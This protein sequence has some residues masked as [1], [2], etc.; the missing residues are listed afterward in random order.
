MLI[1]SAKRANRIRLI[2][3]SIF[4][5]L[6]VTGVQPDLFVIFLQGGHIFAGCTQNIIP[7]LA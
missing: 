5:L 7:T 2:F 4:P 3:I 1:G 6:H